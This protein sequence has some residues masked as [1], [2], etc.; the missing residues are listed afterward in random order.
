MATRAYLGT[1]TK[2]CPSLNPYPGSPDGVRGSAVARLEE[3]GQ[4]GPPTQG[5]YITLS[6]WPPLMKH[7][8]KDRIT[9]NFQSATAE[10]V[11]PEVRLFF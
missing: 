6:H 7:R 3:G 5:V 9:G 1:P 10:H 2:L 4:L 11:A 8:L